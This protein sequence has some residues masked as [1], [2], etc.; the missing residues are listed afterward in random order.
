MA[1]GEGT[2]IHKGRNELRIMEFEGQ[3]L[4][5]KAFRRPHLINQVCL[6]HLPRLKS[7]TLL[8]QRPPAA[9]PG[10]GTP[11]PVGYYNIRSGARPAL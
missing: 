11:Q 3:K 7:E 8:R 2:V 10:I 6:W 5:V 1:N 4:V 9:G